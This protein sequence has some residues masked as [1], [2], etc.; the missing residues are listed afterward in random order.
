M[1]FL[2]Y[3]KDPSTLDIILSQRTHFRAKLYLLC[4]ITG[5]NPLASYFLISPYLA[6][7]C[8]SFHFSF[9]LNFV[10]FLLFLFVVY[11]YW[12]FILMFLLIVNISYLNFVELQTQRRYKRDQR[13]I[14]FT[15]R[16]LKK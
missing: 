12:P 11:M 16:R 6:C 3:R 10:I 13:V 7:I 9:Y 2:R 14:F 1:R 4:L 5:K 8:Y 15:I